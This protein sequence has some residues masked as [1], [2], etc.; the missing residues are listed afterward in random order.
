MVL[1]CETRAHGMLKA[2]IPSPRDEP[3]VFE[4]MNH[5]LERTDTYINSQARE[6]GT[7][8]PKI[9][10]NP[11]V[12]IARQS[13]SGGTAL[14][15]A[16]ARTLNGRAAA[17][18]FWQVSEGNLTEK[19]LRANNLPARLGR[20]LPEDHVSEINASMGEL[21]GLHPSLWDLIQKTNETIVE[22]AKVGHAIV[23]G[24][25]ANFA[26]RQMPLGL[27]VRLV[28]PA[29]F[30][31]ASIARLFNL[32]EKQAYAYNAKR[33]AERRHYVK[34]TFSADL[35]DPENYDLVINTE[36]T[37]VLVAAAMIAERLKTLA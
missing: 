36:R 1:A 11:F 4:P 34:H 29:A 37:P 32:S 33:D 19:M 15:R 35:E 7:P 13:G 8:W 9:P 30:R 12:T 31:A 17:G 28:A 14:A 6:S 21:V 10:R 26:A 18:V 20:F 3:I 25:G 27:H 22:L 16:L 5:L 24:R 23:V 2:S